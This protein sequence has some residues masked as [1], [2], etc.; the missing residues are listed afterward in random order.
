M[1]E[2]DPAGAST[3]PTG[4]PGERRR[5][6]LAEITALGSRGGNDA[7]EALIA[8]LSNPEPEVRFTA[9][10]A[11]GELQDLR[12]AEKLRFLCRN[13][14]NCFVRVAARVALRKTTGEEL[15]CS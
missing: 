8:L 13:D 3:G 1:G 9:A 12:A 4:S 10:D 7:C 5:Q 11:L 6:R 15:D 14:E 2:W